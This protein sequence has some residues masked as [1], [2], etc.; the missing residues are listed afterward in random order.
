M[1]PETSKA[2]ELI[3][4]R[5]QSLSNA[6]GQDVSPRGARAIF[7]AVPPATRPRVLSVLEILADRRDAVAQKDLAA[8]ASL[9]LEA[10]KGLWSEAGPRAPAA[11][12]AG[13]ALR[14]FE[15]A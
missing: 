4:L 7:E 3:L 15:A 13:E 6:A 1:T 9:V 14:H 8:G 10:A 5:L 11:Y 12:A 2:V